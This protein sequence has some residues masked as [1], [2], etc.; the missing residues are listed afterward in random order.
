MVA[1]QSVIKI[2]N[3]ILSELRNH[4]KVL[5]RKVIVQCFKDYSSSLLYFHVIVTNVT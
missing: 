2:S 4:W 1:V 3:F 5:N